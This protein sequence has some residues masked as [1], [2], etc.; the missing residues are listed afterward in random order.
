MLVIILHH[1]YV[2][3]DMFGNIYV[4]SMLK[5]SII[6]FD[7]SGHG[8][9]VVMSIQDGLRDPCATLTGRASNIGFPFASRLNV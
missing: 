6:R 7:R 2:S 9:R 1:R 4:C 3:K 5:S 8:S